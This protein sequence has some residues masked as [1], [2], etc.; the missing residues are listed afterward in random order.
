MWYYNALGFIKPFT[1]QI[2]A[3]L[4]EIYSMSGMVP[5]AMYTAVNQFGTEF[6]VVHP[7]IT[8]SSIHRNHR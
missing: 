5:A 4:F 2:G 1:T 3:E 6:M 8:H 7:N